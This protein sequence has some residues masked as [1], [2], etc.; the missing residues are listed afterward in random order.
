MR[1]YGLVIVEFKEGSSTPTFHANRGREK[2]G[3]DR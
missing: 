2:E 3:A 1:K